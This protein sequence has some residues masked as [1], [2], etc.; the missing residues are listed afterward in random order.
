MNNIASPFGWLQS[1]V[2]E[3]HPEH[4]FFCGGMFR[5]SCPCTHK[6][7]QQEEKCPHENLKALKGTEIFELV[8]PTGGLPYLT[9]DM[10]KDLLFMLCGHS[11][12]LWQVASD[13]K[14]AVRVRKGEPKA[15]GQIPT[16]EAVGL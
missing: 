8:R 13:F 16:A 2:A 9:D 10:H 14:T 4:L 1:D 11:A 6:I 3:I 7:C 15:Y 12:D 5:F